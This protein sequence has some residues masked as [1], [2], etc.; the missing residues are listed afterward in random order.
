MWS[1]FADKS[2][3]RLCHPQPAPKFVKKY[4]NIADKTIKAFSEYVKEVRGRQFPMPEHTYKMVEGELP[5]L[6]KLLKR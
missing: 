4:E 3:S 5:K 2:L 6:E 1:G